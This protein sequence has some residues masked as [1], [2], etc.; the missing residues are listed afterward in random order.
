MKY[1]HVERV[2]LT[3]CPGG[4][5][6]WVRSLTHS[7]VAGHL[8]SPIMELQVPT[9]ERRLITFLSM[10]SAPPEPLLQLRLKSGFWGA[11]QFGSR[12][13]CSRASL[14]R[15]VLISSGKMIMLGSSP[16][17]AADTVAARRIHDVTVNRSDAIRN[18]M[19]LDSKSNASFRNAQSE[20]LVLIQAECCTD[21]VLTQANPNLSEGEWANLQVGWRHVFTFQRLA[22][23]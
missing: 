17:G 14:S 3:H 16:W 6:P 5:G 7:P 12:R 18:W 10:F 20:S 11:A 21:D 1:L 2:S 22:E 13:H 19:W 9:P 15:I 4:H 8:T 23:D